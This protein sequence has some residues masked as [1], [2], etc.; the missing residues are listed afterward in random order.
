MLHECDAKRHKRDNGN[1]VL[2]DLA[3]PGECVL[4]K[5]T[6]NRSIAKKREGKVPDK[7]TL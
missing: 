2:G 3:C 1:T 4:K 6:L 5:V 7:E